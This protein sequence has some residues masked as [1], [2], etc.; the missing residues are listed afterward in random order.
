M[1]KGEDNYPLNLPNLF[2][3]QNVKL[4]A[5]VGMMLPYGAMSAVTKNIWVMDAC[6]KT[7]FNLA[8]KLA[9]KKLNLRWMMFS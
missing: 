9:G 5:F 1:L 4:L 2:K 7:R 3:L 8:F 6:A